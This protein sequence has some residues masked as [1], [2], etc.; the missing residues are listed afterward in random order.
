MSFHDPL[1]GTEIRGIPVALPAVEERRC[2]GVSPLSVYQFAFSL[3]D[4]LCSLSDFAE[5]EFGN[6]LLQSSCESVYNLD[7]HLKLV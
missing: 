6:Y 5:P 7:S 1:E 3:Q 4:R 2:P